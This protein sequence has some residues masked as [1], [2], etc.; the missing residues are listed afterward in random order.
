[1]KTLK[2]VALALFAVLAA[3]NGDSGSTSTTST[4]TTQGNIWDR[5]MLHG[6]MAACNEIRRSL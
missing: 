1:M 6:E 5:C 3:C 4:P 2:I